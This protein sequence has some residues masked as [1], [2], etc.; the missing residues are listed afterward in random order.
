VEIL[1]AMALVSLM[2]VSLFDWLIGGISRAR[3]TS[4]HSAA[5]AWTSGE[6]EYLRGQCF[7]R[8]E[9]GTRRITHASI[10][11]GE[12]PLPPRLAAAEVSLARE[13]AALL[14]ATVRVYGDQPPSREAPEVAAGRPILETTTLL[15]DLR[16]PG[17]CP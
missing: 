10:R 16:V 15:A 17:R 9:P 13:G 5:V 1:V 3:R 7:E 8:L 6:I 12:P 2:A 14:R 11:P 4:E